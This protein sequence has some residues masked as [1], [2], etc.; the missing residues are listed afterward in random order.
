VSP[1]L[2]KFLRLEMKNLEQAGLL[3]PELVL[4]SPHGPT[5]TVEQREVLNLCSSD[6]LGLSSH[7]QVR[8]AAQAALATYGVGLGA[9][10]AV[11]GTLALHAELERALSR[12]LG[13][14][15]T[16]VFGSGH[17]AATGLF[18]SLL[19]DRDYL[20]CDAQVGPS[21]ADGIRLCRAKVLPYRTRDVADLEDRLRRSRSARFR[22]IVTDGV[23]PLEAATAPLADIC[24]LA[25]RYDALV[26]VEDGHG[27]GVLGSNGRGTPEL[28]G[29]GDQVD[30]VSG[31]F[32]HALGSAGG[33]V[34]GRKEITAW[35][36]QKSRP[37]LSAS[38]LAPAAAAA[39]LQALEL[40]G[41]QPALRSGMRA[42]V[43]GFKAALVQQ[44]LQVL[45][46]AHPTLALVLGD[47]VTTQRTADLLFRKGVFVMG[48]CHP[49]VP[50]GAA[51]LC[52]QV[53]GRHGAEALAEAADK[54]G[55]CVRELQ[56]G[57]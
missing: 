46:G 55:A 53:T 40:I 43:H 18:E 2:L 51:R 5:F 50:E 19:S 1:P 38:A 20:F 23:F 31:S 45:G 15:D 42:K 14:E 49:V 52:M 22:V 37:Y 9:P 12:F 41:I 3:R 33:F 35:L 34:S 4:E 7:P 56:T 47:A 6:Y 27:I 24:A 39:T 57:A 16:V 54:L 21:L 32:G 44:G 26:V 25:Q 11:A 8:Q 10:R 48:F 28:L 13:T 17:H 30:V 36:R 29:V